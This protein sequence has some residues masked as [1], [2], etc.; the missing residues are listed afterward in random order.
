MD[1]KQG[2]MGLMLALDALLETQSVTGAARVLGISQPAMS[3]QLARLR[4]MFNDPLLTPSGRK[5]IPTSRAEELREPLRLALN[6]LETL[7]REGKRFAPET[8]D[9]T[10][11]LI[12]TDYVHAVLG[13]RLI[14]ELAAAAPG[15]R[16]ALLP[17]DPPAVWPALES[18]RAD[19]AL[20]TG[21]QL[22][23]A[24]TRKGLA[25]DFVVIRRY[26]HPDAARAWDIETFCAPGHVLVS[27]EGGGFTGAVDR[28]LRGMGKSRRV[29]AS[30][31]SFLLAGPLVADSDL[32]CVLPRRIAGMQDGVELLELPF[33]PPRF[34]VNLLWH[35]KRQNDPAL[36]WF[37]GLVSELV[38]AS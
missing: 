33:D 22:P 12:G 29:L 9:A 24:R 1:I 28:I 4:Q 26:G 14:A 38:K 37:R 16:L 6:G 15:A 27:P 7:V 10:F 5:L 32:L 3:A 13:H 21:M 2:D 20:A 17:F 36:V 31:P 23:E 8:T 34:D 19:L 25:E 30:L 11:R 18:G 35:P